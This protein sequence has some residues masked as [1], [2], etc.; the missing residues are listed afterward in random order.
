MIKLKPYCWGYYA[1]HCKPLNSVYYVKRARLILRGAGLSASSVFVCYITFFFQHTTSSSSSSLSLLSLLSRSLSLLPGFTNTRQVRR[2][3]QLAP[4][5]CLMF[6]SAIPS[7]CRRWEDCL[8]FPRVHQRVPV[9][10][11]LEGTWALV[12]SPLSPASN[13]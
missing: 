2:L 12:E 6:L 9:C 5:L 3:L 7:V 11:D 8:T 10:L 1:A 4:F 13:R